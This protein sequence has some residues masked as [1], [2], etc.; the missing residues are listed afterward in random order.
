MT[1]LIEAKEAKK[2]LEAKRQKIREEEAKFFYEYNLDCINKKI[3]LFIQNPRPL[4]KNTVLVPVKVAPDIMLQIKYLTENHHDYH[5]ELEEAYNKLMNY[6]EEKGYTVRKSSSSEIFKELP[7]LMT[8][9]PN[10]PE[11]EFVYWTIGF[12]TNA[13][14]EDKADNN[15]E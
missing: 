7:N 12:G 10:M 14:M 5:C 2:Q 1:E 9:K 4:N 13:D 8:V 3:Q 11:D 6:I 15:D